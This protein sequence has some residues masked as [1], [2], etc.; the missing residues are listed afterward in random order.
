MV[1]RSKL[2]SVW[3]RVHPS[4]PNLATSSSDG[5]IEY[6][7]QAQKLRYSSLPLHTQ[8]TN[9]SQLFSPQ[10]LDFTKFAHRNQ[11]S[12]TT[13]MQFRLFL[14]VIAATLLAATTA[15]ANIIQGF[16]VPSTITKGEPFTLQYKTKGA[17]SGPTVCK[18]LFSPNATAPFCS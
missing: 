6:K 15:S 3:T 5:G 10:S 11:L 14:F 16:K 9:Y 13:T 1:H 8:L 18:F 4:Q 7:K 12:T 2:I 17:T